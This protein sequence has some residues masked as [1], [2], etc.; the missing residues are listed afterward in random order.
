MV[1]R[2]LRKRRHVYGTVL[3]L[4]EKSMRCKPGLV[5]G[6]LYRLT[7]SGKKLWRIEPIS[8]N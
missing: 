8:A 2:I 6:Q 4:L 7:E 1:K 3:D 5:R